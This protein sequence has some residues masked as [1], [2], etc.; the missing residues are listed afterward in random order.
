MVT[1]QI[2]RVGH[3]EAKSFSQRLVDKHKALKNL[4]QRLVDDGV[5]PGIQAIDEIEPRYAI[6]PSSYAQ[7]D[8][9][10]VLDDGSLAHVEIKAYHSNSSIRSEHKPQFEMY[11][12]LGLPLMLVTT[13]PFTHIFPCMRK[14]FTRILALEDL[15]GAIRRTGQ[16]S[17]RNQ[18][19][20]AIEKIQ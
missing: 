3:Q 1:I 14:Y 12:A 6:G 11:R 20:K 9:R 13:V 17:Y 5:A 8:F 10:V 15:E 7:P 4:F 18:L 16:S 19:S 2:A